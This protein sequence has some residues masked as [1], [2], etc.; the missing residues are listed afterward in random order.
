[1]VTLRISA[2]YRYDDPH[3]PVTFSFQNRSTESG[4]LHLVQQ[5]SDCV[6]RT[7]PILVVLTIDQVLPCCTKCDNQ[8]IKGQ[9]TNHYL[10]QG[11]G[12]AIITVTVCPSVVLC[13]GLQQMY[14]ADFMVSTN[15]KSWLTFGANPVMDNGLKSP[16][17]I[18]GDS[19]A[20]L[21][22]PLADFHDTWR[23]DWRRQSTTNLHFGSNPTDI[24][25]WI[26]IISGNP[27]SNPGSLLTEVRSLGGG[28]CC[29]ST[30]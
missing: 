24:Q 27:D 14:S 5:E 23:N 28:L 9:C 3:I 19:I 15:W 25:I 12:Y 8:T 18:L 4:L 22:L 13:A 6:E 2:S 29:L 10:R 16:L 11:G 7:P 21:I 30:D 17:C 26:R 1:V 20:F